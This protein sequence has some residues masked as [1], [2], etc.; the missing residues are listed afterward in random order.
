MGEGLEGNDDRREKNNAD[1]ETRAQLGN[2]MLQTSSVNSNEEVS[3]GGGPN[4]TQ[5]QQYQ[6]ALEQ[7]LAQQRRNDE[8]M[9]MRQQ[10]MRQGEQ[11]F[12]NMVDDGQGT[13]VNHTGQMNQDLDEDASNGEHEDLQS[14]GSNPPD[15]WAK[16]D[17]MRESL[18]KIPTSLEAGISVRD[19]EKVLPSQQ[20]VLDNNG[21]T[22]TTAFE[23]M[24][25]R[26]GMETLEGLDHEG[27]GTFL[28]SHL[29]SFHEPEAD[30]LV[31]STAGETDAETI[32]KALPSS[33]EDMFT[34]DLSIESSEGGQILQYASQPRTTLT[35]IVVQSLDIAHDVADLSDD[36][37]SVISSKASSIFSKAS[38][39][40]AATDLS[41]AS[42]YSVTQ[43]ATAT[44]ELVVIF[45]AD[46]PLGTLY[47]IALDHPSIGAEKLQRKLCRLF[48]IYA[49]YLK[50]EAKDQ[51]EFLASRLV[52]KKSR[53]LARSVV[54]AFSA[55]SE[56][57]ESLEDDKSSDDE[58][59][60]KRP[61]NEEVFEDLVSFRE[62][63]VGSE[64]FEKLH[65]QL[66]SFVLPK[67]TDQLLAD[68][69][70][71]PEVTIAE[72]L[73]RVEQ[74]ESFVE[75]SWRTWYCDVSCIADAVFRD[76]K[77]F[78]LIKRALF[79]VADAF[80]LATD[81]PAIHFGLLEPPL[82]ESA[83]RLRWTSVSLS[84]LLSPPWTTSNADHRPEKR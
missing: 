41:R 6:Q 19:Q 31:S 37:I 24:A 5:M 58:E 61:V 54:E 12:Q 70:V 62:F 8:I 79:L 77:D 38:F 13:V 49:K 63:L 72:K 68:S 73:N 47:R 81:A 32:N 46:K 57:D 23:A 50:D 4:P 36:A 16:P 66:Q 42:G 2:E 52:S 76:R 67:A 53:Y 11:M 21:K 80:F 7:Q 34:R 83:I 26:I 64:A 40:S 71:P 69:P 29:H 9:R 18:V 84:I 1:S 27:S 55:R 30:E 28:T 20:E 17:E 75:R 48:K 43:I 44:R 51:L 25:E 59:T 74:T 15:V 45:V 78:L 39:A 14:S 65:N 56:Q 33:N 22:L 3:M 35:T 60:G 10:V 82:S